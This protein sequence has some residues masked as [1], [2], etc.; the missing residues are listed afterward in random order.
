MVVYWPV[1]PSKIT[2]EAGTRGGQH[3]GIDFG[4]PV[5]T[6][7]RAPFDGVVVW[8][9]NDGASGYLASAGVW[10]NGPALVMDI[11]RS[12]GLIS[13][14]AH[15]SEFIVKQGTVVSAGQVVAKSGNTGFTSG[16]HLHWETRWNRL[17]NAVGWINPRTLNPTRYGSISEEDDMTPEQNRKL[18][19]IYAG[20]FGPQNIGISEM[21]WASHNGPQ[22]AMYGDLEIG[23]HTQNLVAQLMGQVTA[24]TELVKQLNTGGGVV[25]MSKIEAAAFKGAKEANATLTLKAQ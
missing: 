11:R 13:R 7:V 20:I 9:G 16:P 6:P 8:V 23:I 2:E 12:D 24:L 4:I 10:A 5:G 19:A 18:E 14:F 22:K 21:T 17:W 3:Y 25:D 15:L 1:D